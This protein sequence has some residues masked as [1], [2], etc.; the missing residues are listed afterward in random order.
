MLRVHC[1]GAP[2]RI[3]TVKFAADGL[4]EAGSGR[5]GSGDDDASTRYADYRFPPEV[6]SHAIWLYF[7]FPLSLRMVE[8]MLA[9]RG[10]TVSHK[11]VRQG[12]SSSARPSPTGSAAG[13]P[14]PATSGTST[15]W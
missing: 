15:R 14:V 12:A 2:Q 10:I 6:I 8:E 11:T 9:A 3:G 13:Y 1:S 7:R 4:A 5:I